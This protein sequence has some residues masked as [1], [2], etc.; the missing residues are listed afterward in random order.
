[1]CEN[2]VNQEVV[3]HSCRSQGSNVSW[4]LHG[5]F[6]GF[7]RTFHACSCG[8]FSTIAQVASNF[9]T[10]NDVTKTIFCI[11]SLRSTAKTCCHARQG[12]IA[13]II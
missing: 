8:R 10:F 9:G 11:N 12:A 7:S 5:P 6:T 2:A 13:N 3:A 1:M 4:C